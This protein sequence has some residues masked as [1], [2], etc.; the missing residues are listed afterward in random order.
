M[1]KLIASTGLVLLGAATAHASSFYAPAPELTPK[2]K[3]KP[4]SVAA[5]LRGFY[6]DNVLNSH[7]GTYT[8]FDPDPDNNPAT[9]DAGYVQVRTD[10]ID[11]FGIEVTP[12]VGLH[13]ALEQ[14]YLSLNYGYTYWWY[15]ENELEDE[16]Q[17]RVDFTLRHT[18]TERFK[19]SLENSFVKT[20]EP[21]IVDRGGAITSVLKR[22]NLSVLRNFSYVD[23][24]YEFTD[25]FSAGVG[26]D[27]KYYDYNNNDLEALLNRWEHL[28]RVDGRWKAL[29]DLTTLVGY[30]FGYVDY[31]GDG[32]M[33]GTG[34]PGIPAVDP[35]V[36]NR[37]EHYFFAGADHNLVENLMASLRVG[38]QYTV[39]DNARPGQDDDNWTPYADARLTYNYNEGSFVY[40]GVRHSVNTTDVGWTGINAVDP[41]LDQETTT[42]YGVWEHRITPK[43]SGKVNWQAQFG[44][45]NGGG[46]DGQEEEIYI[47]GVGLEYSINEFLSADVAYRFTDLES[48]VRGREFDRNRIYLG[49]TASY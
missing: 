39:Y 21:E 5:T 46:F 49:L 45:F 31:Y 30:Q 37:E 6:D 40:L 14:T 34:V 8:I 4:W 18:F 27:S 29:P 2:E 38:G 35:E 11:S 24:V 12:Q 23:S 26:Y 25:Q 36:R 1:N 16:D 47:A 28:V 43:L 13:L 20:H 3:A 48:D 10:E 42:V 19:I 9:N 33:P 15:A 41:T 17:H 44:E 22:S 32:A 7:E